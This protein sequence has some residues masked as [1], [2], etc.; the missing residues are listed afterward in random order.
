MKLRLC[1]PDTLHIILPTCQNFENQDNNTTCYF[2]NTLMLNITS[3]WKQSVPE[4]NEEILGSQRPDNTFSCEIDR[5][6]RNF[7]SNPFGIKWNS[8][9]FW[10]Q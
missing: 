10:T 8:V 5:H 9:R 1:V 7:Y 3:A 6:N 4:N 2:T